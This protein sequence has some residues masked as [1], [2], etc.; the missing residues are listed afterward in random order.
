MAQKLPTLGARAVEFYAIGGQQYSLSVSA[1]GWQHQ[2][3]DLP[4][5][6]ASVTIYGQ[7]DSGS[8]GDFGLITAQVFRKA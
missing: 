6:G 1:S 5:E 2:D 3:I 4:A 7:C 8:A